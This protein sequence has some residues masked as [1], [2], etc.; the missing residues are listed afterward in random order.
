MT[1]SVVEFS[2]DPITSD[3]RGGCSF[4]FE[5]V[6]NITSYPSSGFTWRGWLAC[7]GNGGQR[8]EK[9]WS[10]WYGTSG[11]FGW[12]WVCAMA[13]NMHSS[14]HRGG[15]RRFFLPISLEQS[16]VQSHRVISRVQ[17][18]SGLSPR[19]IM[20]FP[21]L[22]QWIMRAASLTVLFV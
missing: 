6:Q 3:Q 9:W 18:L 16:P 17:T 21:P 11:R 5:K 20:L 10:A 1:F 19:D 15:L 22:C 7:R 2:L 12:G 8:R 14:L 4:A 13:W